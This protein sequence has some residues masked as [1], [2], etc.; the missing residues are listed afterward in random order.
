MCPVRLALRQMSIGFVDVFKEVFEGV[1]LFI[2]EFKRKMS[3]KELGALIG[4]GVL[5]ILLFA[6]IIGMCVGGVTLLLLL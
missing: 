2:Q 1:I 3:W 4:V 5:F 6:G